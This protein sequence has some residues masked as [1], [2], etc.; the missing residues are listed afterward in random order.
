MK[1]KYIQNPNSV[2]RAAIEADIAAGYDVILQ[3]DR[4][5]YSPELLR[6]INNLCGELGKILE[7]RFYG[8]KFDATNLQLLPNVATLSIDCLIEATNLS[9]LTNLVNLHRLSL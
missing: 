5:G 6:R 7:V 3:F 9:A 2:D 1:P 4:P 8:H